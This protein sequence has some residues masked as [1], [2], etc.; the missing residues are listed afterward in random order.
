MSENGSQ[1]RRSLLFLA[2]GVAGLLF[3]PLFRSLTGLP[4][5]MGMMIALG[6]LWALSEWMNRRVPADAAAV[7]MPEVLRRVD[8]STIL[9]FLGILMAVGA[10]ESAGLLRAAA[11][12]LDRGV[13]EVFAVAG[14]IGLL[15]SVIDNVPLVAACMGMYP[16]ADA[17]TVAAGA[18]A[19]YRMAFVADGLFWR[20]LSFCAGTG[21]SLLII[22][23]A[24]GVVVMGIE[25]IT[26]AWYLRRMAWLALAGYVAGMALIWIE[27]LAGF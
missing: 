26:F 4:P 25:R 1:R 15:S 12:A 27:R 11:Q 16:V 17:A 5:Y 22:G 14:A 9:F 21:G 19:A 18:D 13:H 10:L 8:L 24:A 23:S 3:V 2:A 6:V 7:R 20:L